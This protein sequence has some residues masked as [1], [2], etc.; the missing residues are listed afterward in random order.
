MTNQNFS[1]RSS[2]IILLHGHPGDHHPD[3]RPSRW[4]APVSTVQ[5]GST[6]PFMSIKSWDTPGR[7]TTNYSAIAY[8][9]DNGQNWTVVPTS[10]V[11]PPARARDGAYQSGHAEL[12]AG[13]LRQAA[14]RIGRRG[15]GLRLRVRHSVGP[16]RHR[17]RVP[18][19]REQILDQTKYQYWNGTTWV[20]NKPSAANRCCRGRRRRSWFGL[21]KKTTYP[22][23][24]EMSVQYNPYLKK[25]VMLSTDGDN[26]VVMRTA[27]YAAGH[28]VRRQPLWSPRCSTPGC[29]HR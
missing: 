25:Y 22:T 1:R 17:L 12:P 6:S 23:V 15:C 4:R 2:A 19:Q 29:T 20:T 24:G 7:W 5:P 18:G 13:Q 11:G 3:R 8:S 9:D 27:E 10:S 14:R 21:V 28:L 26:N 16:Q